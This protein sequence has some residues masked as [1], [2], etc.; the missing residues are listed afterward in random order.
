MITGKYRSRT[1]NKTMESKLTAYKRIKKEAANH[2]AS[3]F[4]RSLPETGNCRSIIKVTST[5]QD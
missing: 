3:F 4:I 1:N 2:A 5:D